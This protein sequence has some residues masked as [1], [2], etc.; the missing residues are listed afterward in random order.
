MNIKMPVLVFFIS[1][2]VH[3]AAQIDPYTAVGL[4][5]SLGNGLFSKIKDGK[6]RKNI[7]RS[8]AEVEIN[9]TRLTT[10]RVK[11][12]LIISNAKPYISSIQHRLDNY[13][14]AYLANERMDIPAYDED[15]MTLKTMDADWPAGYYE[16]EL[17][18]YKKFD[19]ELAKKQ[20]HYYDSMETAN[21][22]EQKKIADSLALLRKQEQDNLA[23]M[24][25]TSGYHFINKEFVLLKEK[26]LGAR[27]N[28]TKGRIYLGS[29]VKI[30]GYSDNSDVIKIDLAG[31]EGY[32]SK[33]D[34]V[35]SLDQI[36]NPGADMATYKARYY[37]K[38]E[39]NY[40]YSETEEEIS[41]STPVSGSTTKPRAAS[42]YKQAAPRQSRTYITGPRGGCYYISAG[43]SK[44]Y[45]DR[46]YCR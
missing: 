31:V 25:R 7:E 9:G 30:L 26:P 11:D 1:L 35:A 12:E 37:Y 38:Y 5:T 4:G 36:N 3:T 6:K 34:V 14:K 19:Q 44:V 20:K 15:I 8:L 10:L 39:P 22:A 41:Y 21:R 45:V 42:A 16:N 28:K 40:A 32:I 23:Y 27:N 29:Y 46:S 43:G 13:F 17:R 2:S 18:A 33:Q 24:A